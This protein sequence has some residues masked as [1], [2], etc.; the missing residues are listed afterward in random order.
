VQK[1]NKKRAE[2]DVIPIDPAQMISELQAVYF[3]R[4]V[5]SHHPCPRGK[6]R[7]DERLDSSPDGGSFAEWTGNCLCDRQWDPQRSMM[8]ENR[9]PLLIKLLP[10]SSGISTRNGNHHQRVERDRP[11]RMKGVKA[12]GVT[13]V[14]S[15]AEMGETAEAAFKL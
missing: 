10:N 11:G 13:V 3:M 5:I 12:A 7:R 14:E 6:T 2:F 15:L 1:E 9:D 8:R 4:R